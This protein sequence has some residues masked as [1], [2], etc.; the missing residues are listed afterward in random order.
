MTSQLRFLVDLGVGKHV[1]SLLEELKYDVLSVRSIDIFLSDAEILR[2]GSFEKRIII[3]MDR[4]FGELVFHSN[5]SHH[6]VLLLRLE[7]ADG[8][9]KRETVRQILSHYSDQL[10]DNFCVYQSGKFRVRKID[11]HDI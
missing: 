9:E 2:I 8:L 5:L 10:H 7:D 4:D 1:E 6:G 3:T 11:K